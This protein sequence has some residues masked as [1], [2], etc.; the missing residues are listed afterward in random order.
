MSVVADVRISWTHKHLSSYFH[1]RPFWGSD[2]LSNG[3]G[4]ISTVDVIML[5]FIVKVRNCLEYKF[6]FTNWAPFWVKWK[7]QLEISNWI[8]KK[9]N[10]A[11][12]LVWALS[13]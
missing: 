1:P 3:N 5:G 13:S 11:K 9:N 10:G 8:E 4:S 6:P 12:A 2:F 7:L